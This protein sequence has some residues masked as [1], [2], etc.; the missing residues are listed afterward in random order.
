[1]RT[2]F[3]GW[4]VLLS[5]VCVPA[6]QVEEKFVVEQ[7]RILEG[8][9]QQTLWNYLL[10][11]CDQLDLQRAERLSIALKTPETLKQHLQDLKRSY[12]QLLGDFPPKTPLNPTITGY[13]IGEGFRVE[14]VLF[15]SFPNHHV[16]A[17]LYLPDGSANPRMGPWPGILFACGHSAN[18]KAYSSYQKT[19]A[20]LAR[21]GFVVLSYDPISQGERTQLP[22]ASRFGTTTHTLLNIGARLVGRSVVWY[23][24]W[25]GVRSIDYLLSRPEVDSTKPVGMT[26]TSGGGT[27]TTFLMA[28]DQRIGPAAPSCYTMKRTTKFR[29]CSGPADGCQ[30]L[31]NEGIHGIDHIDYSLMRAPRPTAVL[32]ATRDFFGIESTRETCQDAVAVFK[33]LDEPDRFHFFEAEAEHGMHQEHRQEVVRWFRQRFYQNP[34]PVLEPNKLQVFSEMQVQVTRTGQLVTDFASQVSVADLSLQEA[35]H[36]SNSRKA[37]WQDHSLTN[38]LEEIR[39]LLGVRNSLVSPEVELVGRIRHQRTTIDRLILQRPGEVPIPGLLF[40]KQSIDTN[41]TRTVIYLHSQGKEVEVEGEIKALLTTSNSVL[42]IDVRGVGETRDQGSNT[43][44]HSHDHRIGTVAMHIG[45]PIAGQRVEDIL[46]AVDF[47]KGDRSDLNLSLEGELHLVAIGAMTPLALHAAVLDC[48][49]DTV[50]LR[51]PLIQS[52]M[53]DVLSSP[54]RREMTGLVVPGVLKKYDLPDLAR[55]LSERLLVIDDD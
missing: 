50:E 3:I 48:R 10:D 44:Y 21:H 52:W 32:A 40:R 53:E 9:H 47:L 16:T 33:V 5:H 8:D 28:L 36:L 12:Q 31:P 42:A 43:K 25:D 23:E 13:L 39:T 45:R 51:R 19:C 18:G 54:L 24:A 17:L 4:L 1:M 26:G 55:V 35:H 22:S 15:E 27:Q 30:H 46:M 29:G 7:L 34:E 20:L 11:Q 41:P 38:C 2:N 6:A 37:F 14:K 49:I